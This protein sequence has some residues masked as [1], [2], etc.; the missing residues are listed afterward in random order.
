MSAFGH[1]SS[2]K[3]FLLLK[4]S[5]NSSQKVGGV[6]RTPLLLTPTIVVIG[7]D[8]SSRFFYV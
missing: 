7:S 6:V 1:V 5:H 4:F 2:H 3:L 8:E